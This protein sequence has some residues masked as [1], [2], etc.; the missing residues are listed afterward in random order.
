MTCSNRRDASPALD[1]ID[2]QGHSNR[3]GSH[4]VNLVGYG[5]SILWP[6]FT[7]E[8]VSGFSSFPPDTE[9]LYTDYYRT[10]RD[11]AWLLSN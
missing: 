8:L 9:L 2:G 10:S 1:E 4:D 11:Q 5:H 3:A 7:V 6:G